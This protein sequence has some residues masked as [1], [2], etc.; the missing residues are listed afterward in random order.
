MSAS[1][2]TV[3]FYFPAMCTNGTVRLTNGYSENNGLAEIC[4][5]GAWI[6]ICQPEPYFRAGLTETSISLFICEQLGYT[7]RFY[8]IHMHK[9]MQV[10]ITQNN[11]LVLSDSTTI[12][13][14][15]LQSSRNESQA[16][17]SLWCRSESPILLDCI[18]SSSTYG[19][20]YVSSCTPHGVL[21]CPN[22]RISKACTKVIHVHTYPNLVPLSRHSIMLY[23]VSSINTINKTSSTTFLYGVCTFPHNKYTCTGRENGC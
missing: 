18:R 11:I 8:A 20:L 5:D 12:D 15:F 17:V 9:S 3:H 2:F 1:C 4:I 14:D 10:F 6:G 19:I 16:Y 13:P 7:R 23:D 21:C 22:G